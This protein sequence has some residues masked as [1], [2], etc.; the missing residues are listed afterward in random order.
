MPI[1][2]IFGCTIL[3][4]SIQLKRLDGLSIY[5]RALLDEL[6]KC[7]EYSVQTCA[8]GGK[9]FAHEG[10]GSVGLLSSGSFPSYS[11]VAAWQAISGLPHPELLKAERDFDVFHA[12]DHLIP[13]L[14]SKPVVAT[15]MDAIPFT[16]PALT[17]SNL[18]YVKAFAF[19]KAIKAATRIITI[20][21]FSARELIEHTGISQDKIDITPLACDQRFFMPVS[22]DE[23]V[24]RLQHLALNRPFFLFVGTIQ[25]RKNVERLIRAY[26][27]LPK[28]ILSTFELVIAG[29][30][31]EDMQELAS[32][33]TQDRETGSVRWLK[34]VNDDD[35]VVLMQ[36]ASALVIPSLYEGFGL[37]ALEGFASG[38]PVLSSDSTSLPEVCGD[39]AL[40]FDPLSVEAIRDA[41]ITIIDQPDIATA[42]KSKGRERVKSFSWE[43]TAQLTLN[44]YHK[45]L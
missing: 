21:E 16:Q 18:R 11:Q 33:L 42:L 2:L 14:K 5:T 32:T 19:R 38:V 31:R 12:T 15:V 17:R 44:T 37:P 20:S 25:P 35:L 26:D 39:A 36:S 13:V 23:R 1:K 10:A 7:S 4:R 45:V 28:E 8:F 22:L 29:G 9:L 40:L 24:L 27:A 43:K 34:Y 6:R 30:L 3:A 41:L